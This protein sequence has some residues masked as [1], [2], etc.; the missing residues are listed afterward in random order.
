M[1]CGSYLDLALILDCMDQALRLGHAF[2]DLFEVEIKSV[3]LDEPSRFRIERPLEKE[4]L[5]VAENFGNGDAEDPPL[6]VVSFWVD[7]LEVSGLVY[8]D[9]D[10]TVFEVDKGVVDL[11]YELDL[12]RV[13]RV[14]LGE[15]DLELEFAAF[16]GAVADADESISD[17]W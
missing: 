7:V 9:V 14:V 5:L 11:G 17:W 8:L 3:L 16:V 6:F 13:D 15:G 12:R 10:F 4:E 1:R 2:L